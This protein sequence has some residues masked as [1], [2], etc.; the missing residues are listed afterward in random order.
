MLRI[1]P[2]FIRTILRFAHVLCAIVVA[3]SADSAIHAPAGSVITNSAF[4][5]YRIEQTTGRLLTNMVSTKVDEL[6]DLSLVVQDKPPFRTRNGKWIA[7]PILLTNT[8]NGTEAF[9]LEASITGSDDQVEGF[10]PDTGSVDVDGSQLLAGGLTPPLAPGESLALL[11]LIR[12]VGD[13]IEGQI[14]LS[15]HAATGDGVP[16]TDFAS[17][18]DG[19]TDAIVGKSGALVRLALDMP[20]MLRPLALKSIVTLE[21]AQAVLAPDGSDRAV[22]GAT[23]TYTITARVVGATPISGAVIADPI[24]AGA[25]YVPASLVL[26]G[27][28]VPDGGHLDSTGVLVA[29]GDVSEAAPRTLSFK[30]RIR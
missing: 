24:P 16:A 5:D 3:G 19:G 2:S 4:V 25:E 20:A 21:K 7:I 6:L 23:I 12:P 1:H 10:V 29:L 8:G 22:H 11:L 28:P 17:R 15:A 13:S 18:G 26:D 30:V 27:T 14:T 9:I